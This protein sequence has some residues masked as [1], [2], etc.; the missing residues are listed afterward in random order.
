MNAWNWTAI[1]I[2]QQNIAPLHFCKWIKQ[3]MSFLKILKGKLALKFFS[4]M[5]LQF[6]LWSDYRFFWNFIA[7]VGEKINV[8]ILMVVGIVLFYV[9]TTAIIKHVI[10][11]IN[12]QIVFSGSAMM[13]KFIWHNLKLLLYLELGFYRIKETLIASLYC[14]VSRKPPEFTNLA[15]GYVN[16]SWKRP[17]NVMSTK[18]KFK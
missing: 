7:T 16:D 14:Q 8:F 13:L 5:N 10:R 6:S 3:V 9:K 17:Y 12:F 11:G 1:N 18:W 15:D 4:F 2:N